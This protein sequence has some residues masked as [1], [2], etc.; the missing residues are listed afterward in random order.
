MNA[1]KQPAGKPASGG[2]SL[3]E[4]VLAL[5]ILTGAIAVLGE[6]VRTGMHNAR[7]AR[8]LTQAQLYAESLMAEIAA[9]VIPAEPAGGV[10]LDKPDWS[11]SVVAEAL[12]DEGLL[13]VAVTVEQHAQRPVRPFTVVRWMRDPETQVSASQSAASGSSSSS[14]S[15]GGSQGAGGSSSSG[16]G[17]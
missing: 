12:N 11:Y 10:P 17:S 2:F 13:H 7:L 14:S 16:A 15:S 3:L 8:D 1:R 6:V 4:V 5:A 9:G